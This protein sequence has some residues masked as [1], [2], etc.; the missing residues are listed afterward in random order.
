MCIVH[1]TKNF[2]QSSSPAISIEKLLIQEYQSFPNN[3]FL[4]LIIYSNAIASGNK[5]HS[6][7]KTFAK[8]GWKHSWVNGIYNYHHYHSTAHEVLGI[9]KGNCEVQFG[10]PAGEIKAIHEGDVIIIPAGLA[11]K[12]VDCSEDFSCVGAYPDG[13]DY[14]MNYGHED[15][16]PGADANIQ[17]LALPKCDPIYGENGPLKSLWKIVEFDGI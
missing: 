15:E 17:K 2:M 13:Q 1:Q 8:N 5:E 9:I 14:D 10:G 16:R 7:K 11:H 4:P 12:C 6:F 3:P